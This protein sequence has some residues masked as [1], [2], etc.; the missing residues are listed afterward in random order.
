M[1]EVK[2]GDIRLAEIQRTMVGLDV[3][4]EEAVILLVLHRYGQQYAEIRPELA[5]LE[6]ATGLSRRGVQAAIAR[7]RGRKI[8]EITRRFKT[9]TIYR[10]SDASS[11]HFMRALHARKKCAG[12]LEISSPVSFISNART[13]DAKGSTPSG[14]TRGR[15]P[16]G[17]QSARE[18]QEGRA[19]AEPPR[20]GSG[21]TASSVGGLAAAADAA[22]APHEGGTSRVDGSAVSAQN[23][24]DAALA[25]ADRLL[26]SLLGGRRRAPAPDETGTVPDSSARNGPR[27]GGLGFG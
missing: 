10:L 26:A 20:R 11:A 9:S 27:I 8:V 14:A 3:S 6:A 23:V 16:S 4:M 18:A 13:G 12:S 15:T 17:Y 7:L 21:S 5:T 22:A 1:S 25:E 19:T 2:T 24:N